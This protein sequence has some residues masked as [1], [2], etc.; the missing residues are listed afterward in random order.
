MHAVD[1]PECILDSRRDALAMA[2]VS[3]LSSD[4][5]SAFIQMLGPGSAFQY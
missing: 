1:G 5:L 4:L 3:D 2:L